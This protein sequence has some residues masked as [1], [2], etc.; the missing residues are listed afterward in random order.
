M[1]PSSRRWRPDA[2]S[3]PGR[4]GSL[5]SPTIQTLVLV[6]AAVGIVFGAVEVGVT[7]AAHALGGTVA[8]GPLLA[9]WGVGSLAGGV[10]A[11]RGGGGAR[12]GR[13]LTLVVL[14]LATGHLS[15]FAAS[16]TVFGLAA[17]LFAAGAAI[18]P[19]YATV[20]SMVDEAA[21]PGT[22][23]EAFAWLSTAI[24]AGTAAGA[25]GAGALVDSA[26]PGS[27]F[28]L[29]GAAGA[30]AVLV[31]IGRRRTLPGHGATGAHNPALAASAATG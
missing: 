30:A 19:T 12:S 24:A 20:Y 8:A 15:L 23:T 26:G 4:G 28:L 21:P 31:T 10:F 25:A 22:V 18:A 1:Q 17:V 13:G 7:A 3:R 11:A 6:L 9:V 16:G 29:A 5:G 2:G 14:A 27:T